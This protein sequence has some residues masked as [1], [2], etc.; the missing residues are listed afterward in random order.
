MSTNL[1][2]DKMKY[3]TLD[4]KSYALVKVI[5]K[6]QYDILRNKVHAIVPDY[7]VKLMLGKNE[8]GERRGKWMKKL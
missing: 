6:F 3:S 5:K 8:L 4:K 1:K 7:V 2:E